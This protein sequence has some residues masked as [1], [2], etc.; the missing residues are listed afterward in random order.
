MGTILWQISERYLHCWLNGFLFMFSV[1]VEQ[2]SQQNRFITAERGLTYYIYFVLT[3]L[4]NFQCPLEP[5][6]VITAKKLLLF[7]P[8]VFTSIF[9]AKKKDSVTVLLFYSHST[10]HKIKNLVVKFF[11]TICFTCKWYHKNL[12]FEILSY[13]KMR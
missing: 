10:R 8:S 2:M 13:T 6:P 11:W 12:F 5:H 7:F 4:L 3:P 1:Y 9:I